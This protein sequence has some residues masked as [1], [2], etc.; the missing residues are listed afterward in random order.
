VNLWIYVDVQNFLPDRLTQSPSDTGR[1]PTDNRA[2]AV[3]FQTHTHGEVN[4]NKD[5]GATKYDHSMMRQ[6][7][8]SSKLYKD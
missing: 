5:T 4:N 6:W 8:K 1:W 2:N 7:N 3:E